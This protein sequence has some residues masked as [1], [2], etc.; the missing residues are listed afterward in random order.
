MWPHRGSKLWTY[1]EVVVVAVK[2]CPRCQCSFLPILI[3]QMSSVYWKAG[4]NRHERKC[5]V[6]SLKTTNTYRRRDRIV[7]RA[8]INTNRSKATT[9][10][11]PVSPTREF[12][13]RAGN[14]DVLRRRISIGWRVRRRNL[15]A[16]ITLGSVLKSSEDVAQPEALAHTEFDGHRIARF[17]EHSR[18]Q[19]FV[20][21]IIVVAAV[22]V[23]AANDEWCLECLRVSRHVRRCD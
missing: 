19:S 17:T 13:V 22:P 2:V 3:A 12:R 15:R 5:P 23:A 10:L 7:S 16:A 14:D 18:V 1:V 21:S 20:A 6:D 9:H 11:R 4:H 8:R